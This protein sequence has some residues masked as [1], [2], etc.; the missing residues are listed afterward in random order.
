MMRSVPPA[1]RLARRWLPWIVSGATL[2]YV[3][4]WATDWR[5]LWAA[6]ERANLPLFLAIVTLDKVVFFLAWSFAAAEAVHRFALPVRRRSVVAL[7]GGSELVRALSPQL[8]DA[9]F[10]LGLVRATG[11]GRFLAVVAA[12]SLPAVCHLFA[13]ILQL[14]IGLFLLEG[15]VRANRE[16]ALAVGVTWALALVVAASLRFER[17]ARLSPLGRLRDWLE[18]VEARRAVPFVFA[19]AGLAAFDVVVQGLATRAFG[20]PL[21]WSELFARIPML[22]AALSLPSF[23]N[24]GTRELAWAALFD[25]H[26]PRD[27][28]IAYA[29]AMNTVFLLLNALI[30][31]LFLGRALELLRDV[32]RMQG[33]GSVLRDAAES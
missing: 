13:L 22:Y 18:R 24:F 11:G 10:L 23:G 25:G 19:F 29:F 26:A 20:V 14:S 7:R 32:T 12:A 15:G 9:G 8:A 28:L 1:S 21:P 17:L 4:G 27:A 33:P 16:V 6:T 31:M 2:A 5:A 30:G 3:F